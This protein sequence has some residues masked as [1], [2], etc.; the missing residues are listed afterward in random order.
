[1]VLRIIFASPGPAVPTAAAIAVAVAEVSPV[2]ADNRIMVEERVELEW[3]SS[4][5]IRGVIPVPQPDTPDISGGTPMAGTQNTT[6]RNV[7]PS[8]C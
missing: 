8:Q 7:R 2:A 1:M 5:D 3:R 4:P 6:S